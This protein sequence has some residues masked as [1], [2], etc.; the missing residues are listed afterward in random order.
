MRISGRLDG[1]CCRIAASCCRMGH[2]VQARRPR[3]T[4]CMSQIHLELE[5]D[6]SEA[7]GAMSD[8]NPLSFDWPIVR[9]PQDG[10]RMTVLTHVLSQ[11]LRGD[12]VWDGPRTV[13]AMQNLVFGVR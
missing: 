4:Q 3:T 7:H 10:L 12:P 1:K 8:P 13:A 11:Y 6:Q 2:C 5:R 9:L